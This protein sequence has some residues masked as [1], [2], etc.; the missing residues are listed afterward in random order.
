L[1][2]PDPTFL[3]GPPGPLAPRDRFINDARGIFV[4][5]SYLYRF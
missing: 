4:K 3:P 1:A 2:N 5:A